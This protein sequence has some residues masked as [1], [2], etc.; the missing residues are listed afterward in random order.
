MRPVDRSASWRQR[1]RP[2]LHPLGKALGVEELTRNNRLVEPFAELCWLRR[3]VG[4]GDGKGE[5]ERLHQVRRGRCRCR[6]LHGRLLVGAD[7]A[8]TRS[9]ARPGTACAAS[10]STAKPVTRSSA[11]TRSRATRPE[12]ANT[13]VLE[14]EEV[15]AAIP[16]SDKTL[17]DRRLHSV[18]GDRRRLFRQALLSGAR[19]ARRRTPSRCCATA[20]RR[21]RSQRSRRPCCSA[22]LRTVLIRPHGEGLI[23]TTLNFDYEVRSIRGG[24][25]RR[26]GRRRSKARCSNSPSTSSAP[27][28]AATTASLRRPL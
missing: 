5:L 10:L 7:R 23:G 16:D 24:L 3:S 28:R 14:P 11:T 19:Q 8:S 6:A 25:R 27:R 26:A 13:V 20:C 12:T 9:T 22:G 18:H 21:R 1:C 4:N 17:E 15:A 2:H